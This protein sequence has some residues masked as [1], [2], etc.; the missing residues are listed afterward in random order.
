[1]KQEKSV[2]EFRRLSLERW[3]TLWP[4]GIDKSWPSIYLR[5]QIIQCCRLLMVSCQ[6]KVLD[7]EYL[8]ESWN[9]CKC[10]HW[11]FLRELICI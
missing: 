7:S 9:K 4:V 10:L 3:Y 1:M 5:V 2:D 11:E 8:Y 6:G